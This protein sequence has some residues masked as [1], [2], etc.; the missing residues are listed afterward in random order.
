MSED[1]TGHSKIICQ[2]FFFGNSFKNMLAESQEYGDTLENEMGL[3]IFKFVNY[4]FKKF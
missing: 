1:S 3:E 2:F 4:L